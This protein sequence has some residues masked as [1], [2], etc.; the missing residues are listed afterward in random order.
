MPQFSIDR[1][2]QMAPLD[3][4]FQSIGGGVFTEVLVVLGTRKTKLWQKMTLKMTSQIKQFW[5]AEISL[6]MDN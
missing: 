3:H 6:K 5:N 2:I 1:V 4:I